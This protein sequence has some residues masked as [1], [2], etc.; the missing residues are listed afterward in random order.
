M[1]S[2]PV[3]KG[4]GAPTKR[5]SSSNKDQDQSPP[6]NGA[7]KKETKNRTKMNSR[8]DREKHSRPLTRK[9]LAE[10]NETL[11]S[12]IKDHESRLKELE[13]LLRMEKGKASS[14]KK[15]SSEKEQNY[16]ENINDLSKKSEVLESKLESYETKLLKCNIDP[17]TLGSLDP[18]NK[19]NESDARYKQAMVKVKLIQEKFNEINLQ[20]IQNIDSLQVMNNQLDEVITSCQSITTDNQNITEGES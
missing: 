15:E 3:R 20:A 10:E 18:D 14:L 12:D 6:H 9:E 19:D 8:E 13:N 2:I 1:S 7:E 4:I 17:V 5:R 16:I 11:K